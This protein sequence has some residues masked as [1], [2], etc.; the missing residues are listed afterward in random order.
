MSADRDV[1]VLGGG[2]SGL[3]AATRLADAGLRVRLLEAR[4]VLGGRTTSFRDPRTGETIDN[5]QHA[6]LG[7]YRETLAWLDR[8]GAR[9]TVS[10]QPSLRL[11]LVDATGRHLVLATPDWPA[12]WHLAAAVARLPGLSLADRLSL[13]RIAPALHRASRAVATGSPLPCDAEETVAAWLARHGQRGRPLE[14]IWEPLALAALNQSIGTATAPTFVRVLGRV[15]GGSAREGALVLANRPLAQVFAEPAARVLQALG[16]EIVLHAP[17]QVMLE[18]GRVTA[19]SVRGVPRPASRVVLATPW[20]TWPRALA[21]D[22]RPVAGIIDA[23]RLT[24][25]SPIVTVSLAFDRPAIDTP[26]VGF[27]GQWAQWAFD[28]SHLAAPGE[29]AGR[30]VALVVSGADEALRMEEAD[31]VRKAHAVLTRAGGQAREARLLGSRVLRE[32]RATFS[33]APGQPARPPTRTAAGGL[34]LA[35]DWVD[36]GLPATIEGA[37]EAGR[38]AAEAVLRDG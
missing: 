12:P 34:Y 2:L 11:P 27:P 7:C 35:S 4:G 21:G 19:V 3:A 28:T 26:V 29:A 33:L 32:P 13:A 15:F 20:F 18:R 6:M 9:H 1:V 16:A 38:R 5:G 37:I 24:R 25:P 10:E 8:L 22:T 17:A 30:R 31:V 36:T 23:A 14:L